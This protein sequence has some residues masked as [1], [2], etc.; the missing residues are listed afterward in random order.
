ML[1]NLSPTYK[2]ERSGFLLSWPLNY[3]EAT[4]RGCRR[5]LC[6]LCRTRMDILS[7]RCFPKWSILLLL[8]RFLERSEDPLLFWFLQRYLAGFELV[9]EVVN[10]RQGLLLCFRKVC[11]KKTSRRR[12]RD[13]KWKGLGSTERCEIRHKRNQAASFTTART[14]KTAVSARCG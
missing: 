1:F 14:T 7:I 4:D 13:A 3:H 8:E 9:S 12:T 2:D 6:V 5:A 11:V 10:E